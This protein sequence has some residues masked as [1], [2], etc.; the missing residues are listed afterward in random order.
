MQLIVLSQGLGLL[1][2]D[3][4]KNCFQLVIIKNLKEFKI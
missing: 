3:K 4:N 1:A 2:K